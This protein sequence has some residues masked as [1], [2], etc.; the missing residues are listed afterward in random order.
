MRDGS[1]LHRTL[2][3]YRRSPLGDVIGPHVDAFRS[4]G[5]SGAQL[6]TR[7]DAHTVWAYDLCSM[8]ERL[9]A[10]LGDMARA[11]RIVDLCEWVLAV[12]LGRLGECL[13]TPHRTT[14]ELLR[15][16]ERTAGDVVREAVELGLLRQAPAQRW[17]YLEGRYVRREVEAAYVAT[18]KLLRLAGQRRRR[19][20]GLATT[21]I[22]QKVT[23]SESEMRSRSRRERVVSDQSPEARK[24]RAALA[25]RALEQGLFGA[26][27]VALGPRTAGNAP[28]S[29]P[30]PPDADPSPPPLPR[31]VREEEPFDARTFLSAFPRLLE[32]STLVP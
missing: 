1:K 9:R 29:A 15:C 27:T 18:P 23:H 26:S 19:G 10:A 8:R 17:V 7:R 28:R 30:K 32:R 20:Q 16:S 22:R 14:A 3:R 6:V 2:Q 5:I 31:V 24:G 21:A 4:T 13:V 25:L 11:D 12:K